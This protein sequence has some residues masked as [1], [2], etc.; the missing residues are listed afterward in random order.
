MSAIEFLRAVLPAYV[1][2]DPVSGVRR[3]RVVLLQIRLAPGE[4]PAAATGSGWLYA[5]IGPAVT[6]L[7]V[8]QAAQ[9]ARDELEVSLLREAGGK[10]GGGIESIEV[11]LPAGGAAAWRLSA[12]ELA[13]L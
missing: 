2:A 3:T 13:A 11:E 7:N 9:R 4:R 12:G 8:R 5:A 10:Q 6:M 1:R